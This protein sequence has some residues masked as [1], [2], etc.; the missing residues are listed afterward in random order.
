M[1]AFDPIL[2]RYAIDNRPVVSVTQALQEVFSLK[3]WYA[4]DWHKDRG[5]AVHACAA[6]IARGKQFKHDPQITGQVAACRLFFKENE[7]E[8][9]EVEKPL[10]STIYNFAGTPDLICIIKGHK[11]VVDYK[12]SMTDLVFIQ[13][14]GYAVLKPEVTHGMGVELREDGKYKCTK[15]VKIARFRNEFLS[16]LSVWNIRKRLG[17]I[18]ESEINA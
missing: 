8:V 15:I 3:Y 2:H 1:N 13:L 7:I 6:L 9:L 10:F 18:K 12:A 4:T 11:C 5:R 17:L 14:G 16:C